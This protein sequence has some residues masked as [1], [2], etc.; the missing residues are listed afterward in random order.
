MSGFGE[1]RSIHI[2]NKTK[3]HVAQTVV[4]QTFVRHY[5]AQIRAADADID[6]IANSLTGISLPLPMP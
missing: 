6:D 4:T 3:V 1:I 5:R 2:G